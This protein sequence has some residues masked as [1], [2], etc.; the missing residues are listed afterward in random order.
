MSAPVPFPFLWTLDIGFGTWIWDLDFGF[1]FKTGLGLD[2]NIRLIFNSSL[3]P[4]NLTLDMCSIKCDTFAGIFGQNLTIN[5]E[6]GLGGSEAW[7]AFGECRTDAERSS[8]KTL[9]EFS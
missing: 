5:R 1:G 2:K 8:G 9:K 7:T 3:F 6:Q 4:G